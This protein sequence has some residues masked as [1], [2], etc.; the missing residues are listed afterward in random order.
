MKKLTSL[1]LSAIIACSMA[2][3]TVMAAPADDV[4]QLN[5][6][7]GYCE[8]IDN[9]GT[10][11]QANGNPC[12]FMKNYGVGYTSEDDAVLWEKVT[13]T[14][15]VK[16]V[17]VKCGIYPGA[18]G[19]VQATEYWIY[20]DKLEGEPIAKIGV[21]SEETGA[22]EIVSQIQKIADVSIPAGTYDVIVV[23]KTEFSGSFSQVNFM[24]KAM[25]AETLTPIA[26]SIREAKLAAIDNIVQVNV[27][28]ELCELIDNAGT[29]D[30][31]NGNPSK[32]MKNYGIG[33]ASEDDAVL[34]KEVTFTNDVNQVAVK[35]GIYP[36]AEGAVQATEYWIY[37][38]KVEGE[39][40]AKISV[41]S[42]ETGASEIVSQIY[43][44]AELATP[45]AAGT[46]DIIVVGKTEN[47]GSFSQVN[48]MYENMDTTSA[49]FIEVTAAKRESD[50]IKSDEA[51]AQAEAAKQA[52]EEAK[53]AEEEA[54][55][56]AE[57][58]QKTEEENA[59][60]E[61]DEATEGEDNAEKTEGG[62]SPIIIIVIAAVVVI[63]IIGA[64]VIAKKKKKQ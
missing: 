21:S 19:V 35:C 14:K 61:N 13:F 54:Q 22:S 50:I 15:D 12:K 8:L 31:A 29:N 25:T 44:T 49:E 17:A 56:A 59:N 16:Q 23:G 53:K 2:V 5:V 36:G 7:E 26:N 42:E 45:I 64:I 57:E 63:V 11:N 30:Q 32:F 27:L 1:A 52:E 24:Y 62:I 46:Y 40:I 4:V 60:A 10:N 34:W 58:A 55:K 38:G 18:D 28:P 51:V 3:F 20:L 37:L 43:K 9:A 33:Y 48:F 47:S 41:S 6:M 39:P